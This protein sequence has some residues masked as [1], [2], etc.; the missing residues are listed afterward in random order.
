M[1]DLFW[2]LFGFVMFGMG[3][4]AGGFLA[5]WKLT[6]CLWVAAGLAAWRWRRVWA[7]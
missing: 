2:T 3:C 7:R 1:S 5:A 6:L 4:A